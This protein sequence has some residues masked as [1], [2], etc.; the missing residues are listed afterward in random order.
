MRWGKAS[1][2]PALAFVPR[3]SVDKLSLGFE[4]DPRPKDFL[5]VRQMFHEF[6]CN[7]CICIDK[8]RTESWQIF[9]A[10]INLQS[11]LGRARRA[12][13][14]PQF[15]NDSRNVGRQSRIRWILKPSNDAFLI[16]NQGW[17]QPER[18]G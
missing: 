9:T 10:P 11:N 17:I 13:Y 4:S 6:F 8:G 7:H 3:S 2:R 12:H 18:G 16:F 1:F 15:D 14:A 5:N